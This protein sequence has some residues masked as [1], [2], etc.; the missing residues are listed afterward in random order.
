MSWC[1]WLAL[2]VLALA[3]A[4][5]S[6]QPIRLV[7]DINRTF[8]TVFE[9]PVPAG[10]KW[11][12]PGSLS[13][14]RSVVY[15]TDGTVEGTV[16]LAQVTF[17]DAL[18]SL[19]AQA[20]FV[21]SESAPTQHY[22]LWRTDGTP[23]G[24]QPL[25]LG[26]FPA[27][28]VD[29]NMVPFQG[30]LVVPQ[31]NELW[32][33]DGTL[34][35]TFKLGDKTQ[36][37][38][39]VATTDAIYFTRL[40]YTTQQYELWKSDGT[41]AGATLLL[42]QANRLDVR[43]AI[44]NRILYESG[45]VLMSTNGNPAADAVPLLDMGSYT[46]Y[47]PMS[48]GGN[49]Y[50]TTRAGSDTE[51]TLYRTDGTAAGTSRVTGIGNTD[52]FAGDTLI[53][54]QRL[55][56]SGAQVWVTDGTDAGT[57]ML[58]E[59]DGSFDGLQASGDLLLFARTYAGAA[60]SQLWRTLGTAETT[61]AIDGLQQML[62]AAT[63]GGSMLLS[64]GK[65][66]AWGGTAWITD[67]T[68]AGTHPLLTPAG[69]F[70]NDSRCESVY[71]YQGGLP[72][73]G[74]M[75]FW[76]NDGVHG[77]E[78]WKSDGTEAGTTLVKDINPGADGSVA[79]SGFYNV[80]G[81]AV[82]GDK[83]YFTARDTSVAGALLQL[84]R[85][86]GTE[87]GTERITELE[88]STAMTMTAV[89][90][91]S[92]QLF[93]LAGDYGPVWRTDG[94]AAGT[95]M[96][97]TNAFIPGD[98]SVVGERA[99]FTAITA[100][101]G[102]ALWTSDGTLAGTVQLLDLS[103]R[104]PGGR[105]GPDG[106]YYFALY[107]NGAYE[108]WISDGT[109]AGTHRITTVPGGA[110]PFATI[111]GRVIYLG[112]G[113]SVGLWSTDGTDVGT[114]F[115]SDLHP[116]TYYSTASDHAGHIYFTSD[117]GLASTDGTAAGSRTVMRGIC[118]GGDYDTPLDGDAH[119][120]FAFGHDGASRVLWLATPTGAARRVQA[121]DYGYLWLRVLPTGGFG[122]WGNLDSGLE[123]YLA[124]FADIPP[125]IAFMP[126]DGV[127]L[128]TLTVSA[129]ASIQGLPG[130]T[131]ASAEG[132]QIC[133]SSTNACTCNV[134]PYSSVVTLSNG[135]YVCARHTASSAP[136]STTITRMTFAGGASLF[137]STT[138]G[139]AK[140]T[141]TFLS[142]LIVNE[143]AGEN[144]VL[145]VVRQGDAT[146]QVSVAWRAQAGTA[147]PGTDF[148][149]AGSAIA[150]SGT[151]TF[152]PG[153]TQKFIEVGS[154]PIP[155]SFVRILS[156]AA[157]EPDETFTIS[158]SV[159]P[160]VAALGQRGTATV[161]IRSAHAGVGL[162]QAVYSFREGTGYVSIPVRRYGPIDAPAEVTYKV[163]SGTAQA[164]VH[165]SGFLSGT[166][167]WGANTG[168]DRFIQVLINNDLVANPDRY[169][170]IELSNWTIS[171]VRA[172]ARVNIVD[173]DAPQVSLDASSYSVAEDSGRV[174]L[175]VKR[176]GPSTSAASV[177]WVATNGTATA[178]RDYGVAGV[179][180]P[181]SGVISWPAGD[182]TPRTITIP[183]IADSA[184]EGTEILTVSLR[185]PSTGL[186]IG[187]PATA[188]VSIVDPPQESRVFVTPEK[189]LAIEGNAVEFTVN[190]ELLGTPTVAASV[191]YATIAGSA[192]AGIDFTAKSGT[193]SWDL[194]DTTPRIV[195]IPTISDG[196][197]ESPRSFQLALTPGNGRVR[198]DTPAVGAVI[199]DDDEVFPPHG[200]MPAGWEIPPGAT[201]G[202]HVTNDAGAY[203]GALSLRSDSI[204]DGETAQVE[205]ARTFGV[206]NIQFRVK[207][208]SEPNFDRLRFF[209][210]D[211]DK[212]SWSG[213]SVAGWQLFS[214]PV[215]AGNHTLRWSY[216]KDG[217]ASVGQ[218]AAWIDA[219]VLP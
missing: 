18:T 39:V 101:Y 100:T 52:I 32:I 186:T 203:E 159:S 131:Q 210:D 142:D 62:P 12:V 67:G 145:R 56:S 79:F 17:P 81:M 107:N 91:S 213:T 134:A 15:G 90:A 187:A 70:N 23:N 97:A 42:Q 7:K 26:A 45:F 192:R 148:G 167:Q 58:L 31:W 185:T 48:M 140:T 197:A 11:I 165:Y 75:Y 103:Y 164:G 69:S 119:G 2:I 74:S 21:A 183:V 20:Y 14:G 50:F 80:V 200:A 161:T 30:R 141:I 193:L 184:S 128:G 160:V 154:N 153:E 8:Y 177:G 120:I 105:R 122:Y 157:A 64:A 27:L 125:P 96:I 151:L 147:Q 24:T 219:I 206:G 71:P 191:R 162:S 180:T 25:A 163:V 36:F 40:N 155:G 114:T 38:T 166:F 212:G 150:P 135:Q 130:A 204:A 205:V 121:I 95:R 115:I 129:P 82:M 126:R 1:R 73:G 47:T 149:T 190:R 102:G 175:Q 4:I 72:M 215:S 85:T 111:G 65:S 108:P 218:D 158:L 116:G 110:T 208:S 194:G 55:L 132:G 29:A 63:L 170:T 57:R 146:S 10:D 139:A 98:L 89:S 43:F 106:K 117:D 211:V 61:I 3:P 109:Q 202:W 123:P 174:T 59:T 138:A 28:S 144:Q 86:D 195:S 169:F 37:S 137:S 33:T 19:G 5:G 68:A 51:A 188:T 35:G 179:T 178:G 16:P 49:V 66:R 41:A 13:N 201:Q 182:T 99:F 172:T 217:S 93:F 124:A 216:E 22:V 9:K 168:G 196:I 60:K 94:T 53:Y 84:W 199:L 54:F 181:P 198:I 171:V 83:L 113:T 133:V 209:V 88:Q 76:A 136:Y 44:G 127:P 176:T 143:G 152:L 173:D 6:S 156:G 118:C 214:T 92:T 46:A 189:G 207:I 34:A 77:C 112:A 87:A 78:L 104:P